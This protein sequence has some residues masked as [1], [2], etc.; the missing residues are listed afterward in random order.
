MSLRVTAGLQANEL[1]AGAVVEYNLEG[2]SI[3]KSQIFEPRLWIFNPNGTVDMRLEITR[4]F[5]LGASADPLLN[6]T[7]EKVVFDQTISAD[8][9]QVY[10]FDKLHVINKWLSH[11][12]KITNLDGVLT[13]KIYTIMEGAYWESLTQPPDQFPVNL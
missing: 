8:S 2:D 12:V 6:G 1:A 4:I 5:D 7:F 10:D 9:Q 3:T 13:G 11:K